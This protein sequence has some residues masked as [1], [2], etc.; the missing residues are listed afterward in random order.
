MKSKHLLTT[1]VLLMLTAVTVVA[2]DATDKKPS[3]ENIPFGKKLPPPALMNSSRNSSQ[4][5]MQPDLNKLLMQAIKSHD[6]NAIKKTL[7]DYRQQ[8]KE[9][10]IQQAL[11]I[12]RNY[13][14]V[15]SNNSNSNSNSDFR[16]LK[17]INALAESNPHN[18]TDFDFYKPY[19]APENTYN[20]SPSYAV[21]NAVAYFAADDDVHGNELW[22]TDGTESGTYLVKDIEP[23]R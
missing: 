7:D 6:K 2:Q 22:R 17:D 18:Y 9:N 4:Q 10:H 5:V 16:L 14:D 8:L 3:S 23:G 13:A 11:H 20:P 19:L 1:L 12:N 21:A 15:H